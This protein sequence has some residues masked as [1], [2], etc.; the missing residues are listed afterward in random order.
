MNKKSL[1]Y[2]N[3][4]FKCVLKERICINNNKINIKIQVKET[5]NTQLVVFLRTKN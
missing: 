4:D 3:N 1:S 5:L 2:I